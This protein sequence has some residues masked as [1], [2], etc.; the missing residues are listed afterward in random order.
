MKQ[1]EELDWSDGTG[2]A[3]S[4]LG[5][6]I[7]KQEKNRHDID[8][9]YRADPAVLITDLNTGASVVLQTEPHKGGKTDGHGYRKCK[10]VRQRIPHK[11]PPTL[12]ANVMLDM[13]VKQFVPDDAPADQVGPLAEAAYRRIADAILEAQEKCL[14]T[15]KELAAHWKE[16]YSK[17]GERVSEVVQR[18]KDMT[19]VTR[20]GDTLLKV[21]AIPCE[22]ATIDVSQMKELALSNMVVVE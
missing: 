3:L 20:A 4:K 9:D 14:D 2:K 22:M 21:E 12:Q 19:W 8:D 13:L 18:I 17:H 10:S 16:H 15:D 7:S 1:A 6:I 5:S 11:V